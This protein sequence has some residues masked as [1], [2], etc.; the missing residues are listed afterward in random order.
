[1]HI[2][3][4]LLITNY[5]YLAKF[6]FARRIMFMALIFLYI[7]KKIYLY[8]SIY[9]IIDGNIQ[10]IIIYIFFWF[11]EYVKVLVDFIFET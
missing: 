7:K 2:Y 3:L 9:L 4:F 5:D 6:Q 8:V 10:L 1:M 11:C